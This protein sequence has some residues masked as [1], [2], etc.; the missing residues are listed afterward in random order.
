MEPGLNNRDLFCRINVQAESR[1]QD[2]VALI[3]RCAGGSS[4]EN[5]VRSQTL[6]ISV[7][8][9]DDYD[10]EMAHVGEDRWLYFRY[11]LDIDPIE[12]VS[13]KDYVA[14][15]G[16]LLTAL[17]SAG[18][19]AVAASDFE[20]HL[21]RNVRR[22]NWAKI[23]R[24]GSAGVGTSEII[25]VTDIVIPAAGDS[26]APGNL[27]SGCTA[28]YHGAS[29]C[30]KRDRQAPQSQTCRPQERQRA[31][32]TS[33]R[34]GAVVSISRAGC[35]RHQVD[36]AR[37]QDRSIRCFLTRTAVT[38]LPIWPATTSSGAVPSR[39]TSSGVPHGP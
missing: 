11:R 20:D 30:N 31:K 9:N 23:P 22:L 7:F 35:R 3:A 36:E 8:E 5:A 27:C 10:N 2:I 25:D 39:A 13:A 34:S 37:G 15:I 32:L 38:V 12:G 16:S 21:P 4:H 17:W 33:R 18:L 24:P 26:A 6:D 28:K 14:A 29:C 19:D 1:F